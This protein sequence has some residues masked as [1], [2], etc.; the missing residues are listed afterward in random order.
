MTDPEPVE[1]ENTV[2]LVTLGSAKL[3]AAAPG[4][5]PSTIL[6]PG[7]PLAL[8]IY[9]AASPARSASREHL[10]NLL[11]ADVEPERGL[12]T[13]RQTIFQL[14]QLLGESA[15]QSTGR[16]LCL[17]LAMQFDR[18][19]FLEAIAARDN[20][21]AV[22][23]YTGPFLADFGVPGGAEFEH[24]ADRERD[25]LQAAYV[26]AAEWVIRYR[27]D[28]AQHDSAVREARRLR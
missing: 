9:L 2:R 20:D 19:E 15:I 23:R 12:R 7:K 3:L 21:L 25:R 14:R 24:W 26:R 28:H 27:L 10:I 1:P 6:R 4:T 18:D 5:A 13:L 17:D 16:E 8:L 11:W 22:D